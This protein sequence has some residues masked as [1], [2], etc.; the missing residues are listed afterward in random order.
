MEKE[1]NDTHIKMEKRLA[2][3]N[4]LLRTA[5]H[6]FHAYGIKAVRMDDLASQY[7]MSKRTLYKIF[8]NKEALLMECLKKKQSERMQEVAEIYAG[9]TNIMEVLVT[10]HF[11]KVEELKE[12]NYSFFEELEKYPKVVKYLQT[13]RDEHRKKAVL[14][15]KQGVKEGLIKEDINL[16]LLI[17]SIYA[18]NETAF[19]EGWMKEY[20]PERVAYTLLYIYVR[21]ATTEKGRLLFEEL[22][23]KNQQKK[24]RK[25]P[26]VDVNR[27]TDA[28]IIVKKI[29]HQKKYTI[30]REQY[31]KDQENN[32]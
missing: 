29:K 27:P 16:D 2:V 26:V 11:K 32:R 23:E 20:T 8:P 31:I 6:D 14:F 18:T 19:R 7:G 21:G 30:D 10:F 13:V 4:E 12:I 5:I 3:Q 15:F 17:R 1:M 9:S 25:Q 24:R 28:E 22:M